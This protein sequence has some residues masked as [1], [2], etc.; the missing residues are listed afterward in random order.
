MELEFYY[1]KDGELITE[2]VTGNI[3]DYPLGKTVGG[4][5][6]GQYCIFEF[7]DNQWNALNSIKFCTEEEAKQKF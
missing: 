5:L 1:E 6:N 7:D 3:S 2:I 4:K